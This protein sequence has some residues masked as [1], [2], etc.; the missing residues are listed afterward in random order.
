M[1]PPPNLLLQTQVGL[2]NKL[3]FADG[4]WLIN[5]CSTAVTAS[6]GIGMV[7]SMRTTALIFVLPRYV[8]FFDAVGLTWMRILFYPNLPLAL[9]ILILSAGFHSSAFVSVMPCMS[10]ALSALLY[11]YQLS[12]NHSHYLCRCGGFTLDFYN[13]S[14]IIK[15]IKSIIINLRMFL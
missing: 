1:P 8:R 15:S 10:V 11:P 2:Q 9:V 3:S 5:L 12:L 4:R 7:S 13:F 14:Y 6:A